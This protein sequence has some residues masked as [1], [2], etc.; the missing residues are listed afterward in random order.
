MALIASLLILIMI[1]IIALTMFRGSNILEI[2][3]GN[4]REN[5]RA[6]HAA[7][8]AL[9]YGEWWLRQPNNSLAAVTCSG[10]NLSTLQ[11]C[12]NTVGSANLS[13][14]PLFTGYVPPGMTVL[15]GGGLT[16]TSTTTDINYAQ[17]PGIYIAYLGTASINALPIFQITAIGYGGAGGP[18]GSTSIVQSVYNLTGNNVSDLSQL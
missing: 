16:G 11:V 8:D 10:T 15:A 12:T 9:L 5:Q 18:T 1:T 6:F 7:Q 14:I 17:N 2:I 3:S 4:T 13:G